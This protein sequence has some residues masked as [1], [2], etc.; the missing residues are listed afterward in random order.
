MR[1]YENAWT[2]LK[3]YAEKEGIVYFTTEFGISF[4]KEKYNS[5]ELLFH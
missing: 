3:N 4:L 5:L 2:A 1:H